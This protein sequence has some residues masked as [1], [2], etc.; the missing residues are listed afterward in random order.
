MW[1][2][3]LAFFLA[4]PAGQSDP[5]P[6]FPP[7]HETRY[8]RDRLLYALS[9]DAALP[10]GA[11]AGAALYAREIEPD[12]IAVVE[13][14]STEE[15]DPPSARLLFRGLH[16]LGGRRFT[17]VYR[18][19]VAL[20]R[21]PQDRVEH[22]LGDAVTETLPKILAGVFD[23]DEAPLRA[24]ITDTTVD[25]FVRQTALKA[26]AF[27]AFDGQIDRAGFQEFLRRFDEER[28]A[29]PDDGAMWDEWM[30]VVAV[31]GMVE[32]VPQV[33]AA[34]AD[35]RI[36]PDLCAEDEFDELLD[37]AI[38]H[39]D[40]R[41]RLARESMGYIDDVLVCARAVPHGRRCT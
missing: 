34:F 35:G 25:S 39:P 17:S 41:T 14:A 38:K 11:I 23:G 9:N 15:L 24:L 18:P 27:L 16:I 10:S 22:L 29:P 13:R 36:A 7:L 32:L 20:L 6:G 8:S 40:D 19:L 28:L 30:S 2:P 1:D 4:R 33:R 37:A 26:L 5:L 21:G 12:I 31:L 3:T